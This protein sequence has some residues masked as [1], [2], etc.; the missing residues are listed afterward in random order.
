MRG[1]IGVSEMKKI[2]KKSGGWQMAGGDAERRQ[3]EGRLGGMR[4]GRENKES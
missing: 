4:D 1:L 2:N 3:K